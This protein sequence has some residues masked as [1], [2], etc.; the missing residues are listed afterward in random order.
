MTV[1]IVLSLW[2]PEKPQKFWI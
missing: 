1:K 2:N